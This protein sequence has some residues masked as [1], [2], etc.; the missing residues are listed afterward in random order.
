VRADVVSVRVVVVVDTEKG[1]REGEKERFTTARDDLSS[2]PIFPASS[3]RRSDG[4]R[5]V[6]RA[7][8]QYTTEA[9]SAGAKG[10]GAA[11]FAHAAASAAATHAGH[12]ACGDMMLM[13]S[14][15][16]VLESDAEGAVVL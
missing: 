13:C 8:P 2:K 4:E 1:V 16:R 11:A 10:M 7:G 3:S 9:G 5:T 15:V 14:G 6:K 12:Q